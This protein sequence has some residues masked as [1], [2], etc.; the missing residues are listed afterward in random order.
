MGVRL[1]Q[2]LGL[3]FKHNNFAYDVKVKFFFQ[4]IPAGGRSAG[5]DM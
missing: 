4:T 3:L 2:F 1:K 5:Q